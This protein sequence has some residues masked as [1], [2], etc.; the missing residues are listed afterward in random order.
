VQGGGKI[1][2]LR[3]A[4][5]VQLNVDVLSVTLCS[6]GYGP[7]VGLFA[8]NHVESGTVVDDNGYKLEDV[9]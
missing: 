3:H 8:E 7:F 1:L 4:P 9:D 6:T 5:V 2:D